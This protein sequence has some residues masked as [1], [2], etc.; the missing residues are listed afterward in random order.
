VKCS[1][2]LTKIIKKFI[3]RILWNSFCKK[4][5]TSE[6]L[7]LDKKETPPQGRRQS[8]DAISGGVNEENFIRKT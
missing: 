2:K 8:G 7:G 1:L 3:L 4:T 5:E 6:F